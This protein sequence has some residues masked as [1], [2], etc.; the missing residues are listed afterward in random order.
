[1][2]Q[3]GR[4]KRWSIHKHIRCCDMPSLKLVNGLYCSSGNNPVV[5]S[6]INIKIDRDVL[7]VKYNFS[8]VYV[9]WRK[10]IRPIHTV[11]FV[12][13]TL[14]TQNT[15]VIGLDSQSNN[16][17]IFFFSNWKRFVDISTMKQQ[18]KSPTYVNCLEQTYVT[19]S[20][21]DF[22]HKRN[23]RDENEEKSYLKVNIFHCRQKVCKIVRLQA[24]TGKRC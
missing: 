14:S 18:Y 13:R 20:R 23:V 11:H 21:A 7:E 1:M 8:S 12:S 6:I 15:S 2:F 3:S 17:R 16:L 4:I 19:L 5:I 10:L 24:I 22:W 9:R